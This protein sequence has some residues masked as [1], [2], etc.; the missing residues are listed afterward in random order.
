MNEQAQTELDKSKLEG[1]WYEQRA[2]GAVITISGDVIR[3]EKD[4]KVTEK[5][6]GVKKRENSSY[7]WDIFGGDELFPMDHLVYVDLGDNFEG[8]ITTRM[9]FVVMDMSYSPREFKRT[10]YEAPKYGEIHINTNKK[11]I[12]WFQ[13]YRVRKLVLKLQEPQRDS[14]M[15]APQPPY[16]GYYT[17]EIER[18]ADEGGVIRATIQ[19]GHGSLSFSEAFKVPEVKM[20]P[21]EMNDLALLIA[22]S[23]LDQLNGLDCWQ[24]GVPSG[25][26]S[27]DLAIEFYK[28][29]Y[30]ARANHIFVPEDWKRD[31]RKLHRFI[32]KLLVIAGLDFGRNEFHRQTPML[33][34]GSGPEDPPGYSVDRDCRHEELVGEAYDYNANWTGWELKYQGDVPPALKEALDALHERVSREDEERSRFLYDELAKIPEEARAD[35]RGTVWASQLFDIFRIHEDKL[36][37]YFWLLREE[38]CDIHLDCINTEKDPRGG[39]RTCCMDTKDGHLMCAAEFYTDTEK[40]IDL[41]CADLL[42]RHTSEEMQ[43]KIKSAAYREKLARWLETPE[44]E[45]GMGFDIR[46]DDMEF[47]LF[48]DLDEEREPWIT[49]LRLQYE[50]TQDILN[51][52]YA[53]EWGVPPADSL[54]G[55]Y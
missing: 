3:V 32:F 9:L 2:N 26:E 40:L 42:K 47:R 1:S 37:F 15:M 45:G 31:G 41:L 28:E 34:I 13:D 6:F 21:K 48:F 12:K 38:K 8:F 52:A 54:R 50:D 10:P 53:K 27:F 55:W 4:G 23:K 44:T 11:A 24:D 18:T 22:N 19:N 35:L 17:Y 16:A 5:G 43:A 29:S 36:F 25:S 46:R 51:P 49:E 14:G 33:R 7:E 39:Y 30:H 20:S